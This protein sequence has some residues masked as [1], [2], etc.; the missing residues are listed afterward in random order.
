MDPNPI[1]L[2]L[3]AQLPV[4]S[5]YTDHTFR[6]WRKY[7]A[8]ILAFPPYSPLGGVTRLKA[9]IIVTTHFVVVESSLGF[10]V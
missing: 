4:F 10:K 6:M 8:L 3:A 7:G 5:L 2:Y 9:V 1:S